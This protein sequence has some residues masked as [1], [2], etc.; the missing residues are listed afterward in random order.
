[1]GKNVYLGKSV[2]DICRPGLDQRREVRGICNRILEDYHS[3][4]I[5]YS[6]AM[7]RLNLLELVIQ[8]DSSFT[9]EE[10]R[11][12]RADVDAFRRELMNVHYN[13]GRRL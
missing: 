13:R 9:E 1:M 6:K 8:R 11:R 12:L 5:S 2:P 3:R 10:K 7:R 4:R